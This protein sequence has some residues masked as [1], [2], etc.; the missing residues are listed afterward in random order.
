MGE[1]S[2]YGRVGGG[3]EEVGIQ[4]SPRKSGQ[5]LQGAAATAS[6]TAAWLGQSVLDSKGELRRI[7]A[8]FL[9]VAFVRPLQLYVSCFLLRQKY[10]SKETAM[11][12]EYRHLGTL[13]VG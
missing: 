7:R 2:L 12:F 8:V 10:S 1:S 6:C 13:D 4:S 3:I 5:K 9:D 11:S